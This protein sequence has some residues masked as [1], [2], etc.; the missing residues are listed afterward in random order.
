[1]KNT[2][3]LG[4]FEQ[5]V[6]LSVLQLGAEAHAISIRRHLGEE[7]SHRVTRGALYRTLDRLEGKGYVRW[8]TDGPTPERD[9]YAR[10][11]FEVTAT[12]LAA[13]R[14]SQ[15]TMEVLSRGLENIL[16]EPR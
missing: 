14:D 4:Q 5:M 1:M 2:A 6:M 12:G 13:L 11:L 16:R 15:R 9:G 7:A 10:R 8:K 3:L